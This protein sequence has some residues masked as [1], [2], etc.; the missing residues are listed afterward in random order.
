MEDCQRCGYL[1]N[2]ARPQ[3]TSTMTRPPQTLPPQLQAA[4]CPF[5]PCEHAERPTPSSR[6][7]RTSCR[8]SPG[9]SSLVHA[10]W[11]ARILAESEVMTCVASAMVRREEPCVKGRPAS[12]AGGEIDGP[13]LECNEAGSSDVVSCG[14]RGAGVGRIGEE[15]RDGWWVALMLPSRSDDGKESV[16][17][18]GAVRFATVANGV[19]GVRMDIPRFSKTLLAVF[20]LRCLAGKALAAIR[21]FSD[22]GGGFFGFRAGCALCD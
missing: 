6:A 16:G 2:S 12:P 11:S 3:G 22:S 19:G 18:V 7:L 14:G 8:A 1:A 13:V 20:R 17:D 9:T 21:L 5:G 10:P 4:A 15:V